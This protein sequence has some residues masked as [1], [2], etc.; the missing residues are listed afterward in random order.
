MKTRSILG[1]EGQFFGWN[2]PNLGETWMNKKLLGTKT[3]LVAPGLTTSNKKL[4]LLVTKGNE[5]REIGTVSAERKAGHPTGTERPGFGM[6]RGVMSR[7]HKQWWFVVTDCRD[8][9]LATSGS[10]G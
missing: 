1:C 9:L 4:L 3:L 5:A 8:S 2:F 6:A 10:N 7:E